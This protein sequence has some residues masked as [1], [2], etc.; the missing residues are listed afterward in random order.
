MKHRMRLLL[1]TILLSLSLSQ[2]CFAADAEAILN[3]ASLNPK[4]SD[5][6]PLNTCIQDIF[7]EILTDDMSTYAKVK[8]CYDYLINTCEY[9]YSDISLVPDANNYIFAGFSWEQTPDDDEMDSRF[10]TLCAYTILTKHIGVCDNYTA[11][12]VAMTQALGLDSRSVMGSTHK[13]SGGYTGHAWCEIKVDEIPYVFDP[14]I[15]DNIAKGGTIGYYRFC[16]AY[17]EVPDKY[18]L[19]E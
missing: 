8:A 7:S 9:G 4:T 14:Q 15:E 13:A 3:S 18:I 12:F 16:K 1:A 5:Y 19:S 6:E 10:Q 2:N 17:G 11:A